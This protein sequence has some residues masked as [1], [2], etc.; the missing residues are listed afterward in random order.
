MKRSSKIA[1]GI[2]AMLRL[3]GAI[4]ADFPHPGAMGPQ[5]LHEV[6]ELARDGMAAMMRAARANIVGFGAS[7]IGTGK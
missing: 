2:V 7:M 3:G 5:M 4:A 6:S 1:A